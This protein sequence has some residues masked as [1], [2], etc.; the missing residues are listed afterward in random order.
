VPAVTTLIAADAAVDSATD[1][2]SAEILS[3]L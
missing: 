1:A 3:D 2:L